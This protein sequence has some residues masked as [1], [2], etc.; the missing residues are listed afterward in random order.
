METRRHLVILPARNNFSIGSTKSSICRTVDNATGHVARCSGA[1]IRTLAF[2]FFLIALNLVS[3]QQ[4]SAQAVTYTEQDI[5]SPP[6]AG[7][8]NYS[9]G[10]PPQYTISGSGYGFNFGFAQTQNQLA[11]AST[12]TSGNIEIT[13]KLT[14]QSSSTGLAGLM[15][16]DNNV[17][18]ANHACVVATGGSVYLYY[19]RNY[20]NNTISVAGPTYT[21]TIYLRLAN[22]GGAITAYSS[23]DGESWTTIGS[24]SSF[25]PNVY[26]VGFISSNGGTSAL[27]T[28]VFT[29]VCYATSVPQPSS[30]L[31]LWLRADQGITSSGGSI[32]QWSDNSGQGNN[33]TQSTGSAQ[34]T[35][36]TGAVN[37]AILP[38]VNFNGSTQFLNLPSGFANLT[39][40]ASIFVVSKPTSSTATGDPCAFGNAS[41]SDAVFPQTVGKN[42]SLNAWNGTTGSSVATTSSPLSNTQYQLLEEIL[43]PGATAGTA[44]GTIWVN[45]SQKVQATNLQN[46]NNITRSQNFVGCG[47]GS[48]NFFQG[49]IAEILVFSTALSASQRAS[50]E[51]YILSKYAVGATPTLDAPVITPGSGVIIP[52]QTITVT[53]DQGAAIYFTTNGLTPGANINSLWVNGRPIVASGGLTIEAVGVAPFFNNSSVSSA[54]Y[55]VDATALPISRNGLVAWFDANNG[56]TTSGTAVTSWSDLST[57]QNSATQGTSTKRPT[58][59]T[60]AINGLSAVT[61]N[62]TSQFLQLPSSSSLSNFSSG[63]SMF[64]VIKPTAVTAGARVMDMG[65]GATSDNLQLQLPSTTSASLYTYNGSTPSSVT[66][67][68]GITLNQF[69]L[70]EAIDDGSGTASIFTNG[71][72]GGQ[73]TSMGTI[74]NIT[75][76]NNFIGQGSAGGNYFKG[77]IAELI[78]YNRGISV[79]ERATLEGYLLSKYQLLT[80]NTTPAPVMSISTSTLTAPTQVAIEARAGATIR[81]TTNGATPTTSSPVY[82]GPIQIPYTLTVKAIAVLNGISSS[83]TSNTYTLNSTHYPAPGSTTTPLQINTQLPGVNIPQDS[84][85]H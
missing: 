82:T 26:N 64:A 39:N 69:Q 50:V 22:N 11:Y 67:S 27:N 44:T 1:I 59:T 32:S 58:L 57:N 31:A 72:L 19:F 28:A 36:A 24:T 23:A 37:S 6:V 54:T 70:L 15:M 76:A 60:N 30:N 45:G 35:L 3:P 10:N 43:L 55:E 85:Q 40:G 46:L 83:V 62:G 29:N 77:Q 75:R 61:F 2:L 4:S 41:N 7:S 63:V 38:T 34:P 66:S 53:Q 81:F 52:P 80:A 48:T 51:S 33:A 12:P 71:V 21:G 73:N 79:T 42:A 47:I 20:D 18:I 14:S 49:G 68:S 78:L 74:N 25:M 5:C 16:R 17:C 8:F 9:A 13:A 84:N 65:N 56:V